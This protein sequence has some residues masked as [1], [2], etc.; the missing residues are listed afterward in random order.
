MLKMKLSAK[1]HAFMLYLHAL[2][3]PDNY[4]LS[5]KSNFL[6]NNCDPLW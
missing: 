2:F 6:V 4:V 5:G 3:R 1:S